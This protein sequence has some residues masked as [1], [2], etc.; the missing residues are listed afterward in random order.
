MTTEPARTFTRKFW[1]YDPTSVDAHIEMLTAKQR[2]LRDDVER[3]TIRLKESGDETAA[4]RQEVAELTDTSPTPHA[5]QKRMACLL[6]NAVDEVAEMHAEARAEAAA[7]IR[8]AEAQVQAERRKAE[9]LAADMAS[10]RQAVEAELARMRAEAQSE[11]DQ[12]RQDAEQEREQL[13]ADAKQEADH[14]REQA[15]Q[16]VDEASQHRIQILEQLVGVYRDLEPI[17]AKLESAYQEA[18]SR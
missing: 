7:L 9:E 6:Q 4:L 14:Y 1:G 18:G 2:L 13:I 12:A 8:E 17:P 15:R 10:Q 3:L 5:I 16:A 11:V